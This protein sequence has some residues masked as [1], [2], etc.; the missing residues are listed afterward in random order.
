MDQ[1]PE[2]P[3]NHMTHE[4]LDQMA[5]N[6]IK[7]KQE[8]LANFKLFVETQ[9]DPNKKFSQSQGTALHH[10]ASNSILMVKY[11]VES[12]PD[13]IIDPHD[14]WGYTPL[15]WAAW[16]GNIEIVG[17]LIS[18]GADIN[19][20]T[21]QGDTALHLAACKKH[22]ATVEYLLELGIDKHLTN[23]DGDTAGF[24]AGLVGT[25]H[26]ANYVQA[27]EPFPTKGVF[28]GSNE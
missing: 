21:K 13:L 6:D 22:T 19:K 17:Y 28:D 12:Y 24:D 18:H 23:N 9:N 10:A 27:Y 3:I 8:Q 15:H 14:R 5:S 16:F 7:Q 20:K 2:D 1:S 11:L 25:Q 26:M 4:E